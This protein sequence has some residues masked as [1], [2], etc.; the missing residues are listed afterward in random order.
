M[1]FQSFLKNKIPHLF[2]WKELQISLPI[3][4]S[5]FIAGTLIEPFIGHV[6]VGI[7]FMIAIGV[8]GL[9]FA[10]I[11]IFSLASLLILVYYYLLFPPVFTFRIDEPKDLPTVIALFIAAVGIGALV[12][13]LKNQATTLRLRE[14]ATHTLYVLARELTQAQ[15]LDELVR[16]ACH[17]MRDVFN[18]EVTIALI[19][20]GAS[21]QKLHIEYQSTSQLQANLSEAEKILQSFIGKDKQQDFVIQMTDT[22]QAYIPLIGREGIVGILLIGSSKL[23]Q[24]GIER[25]RLAATFAHQIALA[26]ERENFHSQSRSLEL[27]QKTEQLYK[28]L[29]NS[30]S[31]ELKTPLVAITGSASAIMDE[32]ARQDPE[33]V[34]NLASEIL[35]ASQRLRAVVENLL[36]MSRIDSGLLK[37]KCEPCDVRD[38]LAVVLQKLE[39]EGFPNQIK[40]Y[41]AAHIPEIWIDHILVD[42]ALSNII[43]NARIYA[44]TG[45][46]IEVSVDSDKTWV[47]IKVRDHG[48]GLPAERIDR[49]FEK[50]YRGS[51]Q[52]PGGLGLGL[53]IALGFIEAQGGQIE[54]HNHPEGGAQFTIR[55]ASSKLKLDTASV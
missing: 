7:F 4:A 54:A 28:T 34:Q 31:H 38:L 10:R 35:F 47:S 50:F 45:T 15:S 6:A 42:Q 8:S 33:L 53:S 5:V 39:W 49:I 1:P 22:G 48:P 29:L 27:V 18:Q 32:T 40:T 16:I 3:L 9:F 26:I 11:T 41:F 44:P 51:P 24:E 25:Q 13:R 36:D 19:K 17:S 52:N 21:D 23:L 12:N 55:L 37:P 30:V 20:R 46:P 2:T 43:Q 14:E